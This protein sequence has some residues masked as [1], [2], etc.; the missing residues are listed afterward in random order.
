MAKIP[1]WL[2]ALGFLA[3]GSTLA[4]LMSNS[5]RKPQVFACYNCGNSVTEEK[6]SCP[7]CGVQFDWTALHA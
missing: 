6:P 1:P 2:L 3:G 7:V 4:A 5:R